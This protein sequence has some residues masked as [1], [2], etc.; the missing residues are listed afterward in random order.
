MPSE[1]FVMHT[2]KVLTL[3]TIALAIAHHSLAKPMPEPVMMDIAK[4][5][6]PQAQCLR[7]FPFHFTIGG[8]LTRIF[9]HSA[10]ESKFEICLSGK[11][12]QN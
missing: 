6:I 3:W 9:F 11:K 2:V 4:A 12:M 7:L 8:A 1:P 10:W 5:M